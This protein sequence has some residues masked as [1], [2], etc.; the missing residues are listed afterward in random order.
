[1]NGYKSVLVMLIFWTTF[2][3]SAGQWTF[4]EITDPFTDELITTYTNFPL[5]IRCKDTDLGIYVAYD[6]FL[7]NDDVKV[8][9]R[10]DKEKAVESEWSVSTEGTSVFVG[11]SE[12][13]D[14]FR[15]VINS[16]EL[17]LNVY[18]Y[19]NTSHFKSIDLTGSVLN[20]FD[21]IA[22]QCGVTTQLSTALSDAKSRVT[23]KQKDYIERWGPKKTECSKGVLVHLGYLDEERVDGEKDEYLYEAINAVNADFPK[24]CSELGHHNFFVKDPTI[25]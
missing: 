5:F 13:A 17:I 23:K 14:F 9:Y 4:N 16:E 20:K 22:T 24:I 12:K 19:K 1:M 3:S 7:S 21:K 6:D 15:K 2:S 25:G 11:I 18:D 10:F 8:M